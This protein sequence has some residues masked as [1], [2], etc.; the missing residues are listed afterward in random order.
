MTYQNDDSIAWGLTAQQLRY[1]NKLPME[2]R[3]VVCAPVYSLLPTG[4]LTSAGQNIRM[5][6]RVRSLK[7]RVYF[8]RKCS[9][10]YWT[11][12]HCLVKLKSTITLDTFQKIIWN[13]RRKFVADRV[14][15]CS[16]R[17]PHTDTNYRD[18]A[19]C[20]DILTNV[21]RSLSS[22]LLLMAM[23]PY[24]ICTHTHFDNDWCMHACEPLPFSYHQ[25]RDSG[26]T[27][28]N[29]NRKR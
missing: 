22:N 19:H 27:R 23:A 7:K 11:R 14:Q 13:L 1:Y 10:K 17:V 25:A 28:K 5:E 12:Y 16:K 21:T 26:F 8:L 20:N 4:K 9:N 3:C 29:N 24:I 6:A 18:L 15:S 2:L